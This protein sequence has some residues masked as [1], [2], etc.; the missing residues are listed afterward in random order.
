M[1]ITEGSGGATWPSDDQAGIDQ[2]IADKWL[3]RFR[4]GPGAYSAWQELG[5]MLATNTFVERQWARWG[6]EIVRAMASTGGWA[7]NLL[8]P[9]IRAD[10]LVSG[11]T[12]P[13]SRVLPPTDAGW[14]EFLQLAP[15]SDLKFTEIHKIG[16]FWWGRGIPMNLLSSARAEAEANVKEAA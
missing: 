12:P 3:L 16:T 9:A 1:R 7:T 15:A 10:R 13:F 2:A 14:I 5:W 11:L 8:V 6:E 4:D